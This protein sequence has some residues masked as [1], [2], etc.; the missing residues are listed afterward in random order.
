MQTYKLR[1]GST[2]SEVIVAAILLLT[3]IGLLTRG[4]V[5]AKQLWQDAR[6]YQL[7]LDELSNQLELLLA[8]EPDKRQAAIDSLAVSES[9][10]RAVPTAQ[11]TVESRDDEDGTSL[12]VSIASDPAERM[13]RISLVGWLP[14]E[15][16]QLQNR[17][18]KAGDTP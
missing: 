8:L 4:T 1:R 15:Q 17:S 14:S 3:G 11:L 5:G 12:T 9:L 6:H 13:P 7:A 16:S 10:Q 2:F 18:I